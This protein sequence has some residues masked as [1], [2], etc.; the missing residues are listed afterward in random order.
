MS[1]KQKSET[2]KKQKIINKIKNF[3]SIIIIDRKRNI[4]FQ[5]KY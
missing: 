2:G 3:E 4:I 5:D 1:R